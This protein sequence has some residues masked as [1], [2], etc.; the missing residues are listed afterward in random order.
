MRKAMKTTRE[1]RKVGI[2][3]DT[4]PESEE[5]PELW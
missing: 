4:I 2:K 1:M 5:A 3:V